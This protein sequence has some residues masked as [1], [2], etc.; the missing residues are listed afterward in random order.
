MKKKLFENNVVPKR[1][2]K[3]DNVVDPCPRRRA[4]A[5]N[6]LAAAAVTILSLLLLELSPILPAVFSDE[7]LEVAIQLLSSVETKISL[8]VEL[9]VKTGVE[10]YRKT[11]I[12]GC[13][14]ELRVWR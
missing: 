3:A 13:F 5:D 9:I 8:L 10:E 7:G 11:L 2:T 6:V 14:P 12:F 4:K 1:K